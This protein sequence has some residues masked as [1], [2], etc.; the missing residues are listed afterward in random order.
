MDPLRLTIGL[1]PLA[2]YLLIVGVIG[3]RARPLI[4]N[5]HRDTTVLLLAIAGLVV[6]GPLELFL[7]EA[8]IGRWGGWVW[9]PM[10]T[11][12]GL[13]AWFL[14][15]SLPPRIVI[16]NMTDDRFR[17][18]LAEVVRRL[19]PDARWAGDTVTLPQLGV[20]CHLEYYSLLQ[21]V[22][23]VPSGS[24]Q[25]AVGWHRF[26]MALRNALTHSSLFPFP[27]VANPYGAACI[28][29]GLGLGAGLL[30]YLAYDPGAVAV[31]LTD[32]LRI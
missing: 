18:V 14:V 24:K 1:E 28:V 13:S 12:F 32:L 8:A 6:I 5:G 26:E 23:L 29:L 30:A 21:N 27:K 9:I 17:P 15:L 25:D 16:Y 19:D 11:L 7:P 22:Q 31:A 4:V 20:H 3:W 2:V 10:L